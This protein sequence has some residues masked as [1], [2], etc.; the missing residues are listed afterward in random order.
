MNNSP[1]APAVA[2][3]IGR[4]QV[5]HTAQLALLRRALAAAPACVVVLGSAFQARYR[6]VDILLIDEEDPAFAGIAGHSIES[7]Q[8]VIEAS[9]GHPQGNSQW[10][11]RRVKRLLEIGG[12][13]LAELHHPGPAKP[14]RRVLQRIEIAD[15]EFRFQP[16]C[17][18]LVCTAI[19]ADEV[20][21]GRMELTKD[22]KIDGSTA[23]NDDQVVERYDRRLMRLRL[24]GV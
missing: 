3:Y 7:R 23:D 19:C 4:F 22:V 9:P 21:T 10:C 1:K 16:G 5:F 2:V 6:D 8:R 24:Q 13:L 18:D 11:P 12:F 15:N 14:G 20:P 17:N